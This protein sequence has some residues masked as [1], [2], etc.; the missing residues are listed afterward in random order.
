MVHVSYGMKNLHV[1]NSD[2][3]SYEA[4]LAGPAVY[5]GFEK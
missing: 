4:D 1:A 5:G 2:N 3:D